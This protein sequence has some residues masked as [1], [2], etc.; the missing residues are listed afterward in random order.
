MSVATKRERK[1][2]T[3]IKVK[4]RVAPPKLWKV[5]MLNDDVTTFQFVIMVLTKIFNYSFNE[6]NVMAYKIDQ[7]GQ[8]VVGRYIKSIA[9]AKRDSAIDLAREAGFPFEITIEREED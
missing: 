7:E 5:I 4:E 6:A 9:E 2:N 8:G 1:S 3:S